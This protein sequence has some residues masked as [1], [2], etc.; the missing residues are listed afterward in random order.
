MK[1]VIKILPLLFLLSSLSNLA[2]SQNVKTLATNCCCEAV[3]VDND[4]V[5]NN[6]QN[7][8]TNNYSK[9]TKGIADDFIKNVDNLKNSSIM[10]RI[11][12]Q[13]IH[14]QQRLD[15]N[16]GALLTIYTD[17]HFQ[18][19]FFCIDENELYQN[20]FYVNKY[21]LLNDCLENKVTIEIV[22]E[23]G[24][25]YVETSPPLYFNY[26]KNDPK[27]VHYFSGWFVLGDYGN[28]RVPNEKT[29]S[30]NENF[31]MEIG[32]IYT[33]R[34]FV[35]NRII[36]EKEVEAMD[37]QKEVKAFNR[38]KKR[39]QRNVKKVK[40]FNRAKKRKQR[41]VKKVKAFNRAK[42]KKTAKRRS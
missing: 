18:D 26:S 29:Q 3:K 10:G 9:I 36:F 4:K 17:N 24:N 11:H 13:Y 41:N 33:I 21:N 8:V 34:M 22:D 31:N 2:H 19:C 30:V 14:G 39:K 27:N 40:A 20:E 25:T 42:K 16:E 15:K 7:N 1:K 12:K 6:I 5:N 37:L 28:S 38:A 23:N 32:K 35:D